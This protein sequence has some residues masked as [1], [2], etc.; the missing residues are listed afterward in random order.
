[1]I[2]TLRATL[3]FFKF[4]KDIYLSLLILLLINLANIIINFTKNHEFYG[5][6][7]Y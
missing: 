1:M 6:I 7:N 2:G 4:K 3:S 5:K